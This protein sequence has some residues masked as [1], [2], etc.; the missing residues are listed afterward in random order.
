MCKKHRLNSC[1]R[2]ATA[3]NCI[4][5]AAPYQ[6]Q[7]LTALQ[8]AFVRDTHYVFTAGKDGALKYW[9]ADRWELLLTLEG[10][11]GEAWALAMS[12]LGS[13]VVT[14][15]AD[16]SLRRWG[17]MEEPFFAE[18]EREK[19]LESLFE[20]DVEVSQLADHSSM[21]LGWLRRMPI[22]LHAC[23]SRMCELLHCVCSFLR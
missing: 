3:C 5:L 11:R 17:R 12:S 19:R 4:I 20:A 7:L 13:F 16:R 22:H 9:D 8:V 18:E 14:G 23:K 21:H 2:H 6:G 1:C 15:G 10:H